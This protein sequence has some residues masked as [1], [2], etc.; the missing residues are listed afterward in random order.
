[1][2]TL[3]QPQP[4][5]GPPQAPPLPPWQGLLGRW[6]QVQADRQEPQRE[7]RLARTMEIQSLGLL[8]PE[9]QIGGE[10]SKEYLPQHMLKDLLETPALHAGNLTEHPGGRHV[11][12]G[13]GTAWLGGQRD[14]GRDMGRGKG[15][16][17][18]PASVFCSLEKAGSLSCSQTTRQAAAR[19][20]SWT[21]LAPEQAPWLRAHHAGEAPEVHIPCRSV[22]STQH[23]VLRAAS[24]CSLVSNHSVHSSAPHL[25]HCL[26]FLHVPSGGLSP[27]ATAPCKSAGAEVAQGNHASPALSIPCP[28]QGHVLPSAQSKADCNPWAMSDVAPRP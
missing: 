5:P 23:H 17:S 7:C 3:P 9:K 6:S 8:E 27:R 22:G 10:Y 18:L 15:R 21:G 26:P 16:E 25:G 19:T 4:R 2:P 11:P 24:A 1:M 13:A 20:R 14:K 28:C 12:G